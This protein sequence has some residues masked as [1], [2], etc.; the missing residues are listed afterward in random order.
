MSSIKC[1]YCPRTFSSK[2]G[3]TQHVNR[4]LPPPDDSDDDESNLVTDVSNMSLDSE[5]FI[6]DIEEVKKKKP[7][8]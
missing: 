6:H 3:Y 2:S 5:K 1:P 7:I 8:K 4:C